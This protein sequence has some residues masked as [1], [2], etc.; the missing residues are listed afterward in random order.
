MTISGK[1]TADLLQRGSEYMEWMARLAAFDY[2]AVGPT[3]DVRTD[4]TNPFKLQLSISPNS[5]ETQQLDLGHIVQVI[6][7]PELAGQ[8]EEPVSRLPVSMTT[9]SADGSLGEAIAH[10]MDL[11]EAVFTTADG[12][13]VSLVTIGSPLITREARHQLVE[14][15]TQVRN[16]AHFVGGI[17][18]QFN[19]VNVMFGEQ[20]RCHAFIVHKLSGDPNEATLA[21]NPEIINDWR[22]DSISPDGLTAETEA[23]DGARWLVSIHPED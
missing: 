15:A 16:F 14:T 20:T 5:E 10:S 19:G 12:I 7:G 2:L 17:A 11:Y 9:F 23:D 8:L 13:N 22:P 21:I 18:L 6:G 3:A 1:E 4:P